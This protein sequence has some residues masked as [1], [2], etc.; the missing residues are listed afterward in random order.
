[1]PECDTALALFL[2][3]FDTG[4]K[5]SVRGDIPCE[6]H[7]GLKEDNSGIEVPH[8]SLEWEITEHISQGN[9]N[10][11]KKSEGKKNQNAYNPEQKGIKGIEY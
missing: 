2:W 1:M 5:Y 10:N 9:N 11:C 4:F 6:N 7:W 8:K 3:H